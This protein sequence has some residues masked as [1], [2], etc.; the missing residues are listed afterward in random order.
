MNEIL[1]VI[2]GDHTWVELF[3]YFWYFMIGYVLYGL[4][5]TAN[6]DVSSKKTPRKWSWKFWFKDNWRRYLITI[7]STY[8][9]FIFYVQF[10]GHDFSN[11]EALMMGLIG[12]GVGALAKKRLK[13][14]KGNRENFFNG[15]DAG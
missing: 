6:R 13:F 5:E 14:V 11:F 8:I 2:F 4:N 12:D 10:S 15:T 7:L 3:G 1:K 9:M